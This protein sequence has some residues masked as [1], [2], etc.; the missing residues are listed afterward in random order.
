[1]KYLTVP[2]L[3]VSV[4]LVGCNQEYTV[5]APA[6]EDKADPCVETHVGLLCD[7]SSNP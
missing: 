4:L 7:S 2:L 5:S 3:V 6:P 1:M